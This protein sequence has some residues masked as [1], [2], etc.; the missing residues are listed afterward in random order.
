MGF[1]VIGLASLGGNSGAL[2]A[3]GPESGAEIRPRPIVG[4]RNVK[5]IRFR[6]QGPRSLGLIG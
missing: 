1:G 4:P 6:P 5:M 2:G 3:S